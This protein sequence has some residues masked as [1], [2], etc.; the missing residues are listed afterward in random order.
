MLQGAKSFYKFV[1]TGLKC[2]SRCGRMF[3]QINR[4]EV[5]ICLQLLQY[6]I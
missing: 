3:L 2:K 1:E 4:K 6:Q 5:R